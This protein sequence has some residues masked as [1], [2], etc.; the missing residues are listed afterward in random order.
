MHQL[1]YYV[2]NGLPPDLAHDVFKWIAVDVFSDCISFYFKNNTS[3][4]EFLNY[5][6]SLFDFTKLDRRNK[7]QSLKVISDQYFKIKKTACEMW[8]IVRLIPLLVG[9]KVYEGNQTWG[10]VITFY[11]NTW[12]VMCIVFYS[13]SVNCFD[14]S[15]WRIFSKIFT[16]FSRCKCQ[17]VIFLT[18][19]PRWHRALDLLWKL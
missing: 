15:N 18:T 10:L 19:I 3:S 16:A 11:T 12:K 8:N 5:C 7:L 6:I 2:I 1:K 4:F 9:S 14:I 13:K 17:R